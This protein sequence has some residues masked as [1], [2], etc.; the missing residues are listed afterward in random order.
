MPIELNV[1]IDWF[2]N[3]PRIN[4]N[5]EFKYSPGWNGIDIIAHIITSVN[6]KD[7]N[8]NENGENDLNGLSDKPGRNQSQFTFFDAIKQAWIG[9]Y[10]NQAA[11]E[12]QIEKHNGFK[13][14]PNF[15]IIHIIFINVPKYQ[16]LQSNGT[17]QSKKGLKQL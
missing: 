15:W 1:H 12:Y 13:I 4:I 11:I 10:S 14:K 16:C 7:C 6:H 9:Y 3:T 8:A 5:Q 2:H 17:K